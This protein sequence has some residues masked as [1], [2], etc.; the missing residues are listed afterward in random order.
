M[1]MFSR[2]ATWFIP[3]GTATVLLTVCGISTKPVRQV[4]RFEPGEMLHITA[5]FDHR[6]VDGSPA[7][8]CMKQ[9]T[10]LVEN[11]SNLD[12]TGLQEA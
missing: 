3:L 12:A 5:S 1:G 7:A 6:I 9:Y 10:E 4:D 2:S 11:G 8:R